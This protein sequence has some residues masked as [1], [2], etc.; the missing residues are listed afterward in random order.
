MAWDQVEVLLADIELPGM[1]GVQ[2]IAQVHLAHPHILPMAF[3]IHDARGTV[4]AALKA[5][6]YGYVL[7]GGPIQDLITALRELA[8]GGSPMTPAIARMVILEF[9]KVVDH[10]SEVEELSAREREILSS[11]AKGLLYKEIAQR[12]SLSPHTVHTHIKNIYAKLHAR[13]R[14]EALYTARVLGV[15]PGT[16]GSP[17]P[18]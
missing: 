2:L 4:F 13:S 5:G 17:G 16:T 10:V 14:G 7:K 1:S 11:V 3:T 12:T 6:A 18:S 15:L 9:H 8:A